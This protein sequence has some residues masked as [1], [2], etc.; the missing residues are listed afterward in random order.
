MGRLQIPL[1]MAQLQPMLDFEAEG[2][3]LA[4]TIARVTREVVRVHLRRGARR[5]RD[6]QR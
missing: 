4:V 5:H 3:N 2:R 1:H 6:D